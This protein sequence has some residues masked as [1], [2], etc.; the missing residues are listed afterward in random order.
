MEMDEIIKV[1][2]SK[3]EYIAQE[4]IT[5]Y[6][7]DFPEVKLTD[8]IKEAA[9][10]R[11]TSQLT[12]Q[13]SKFRFNTDGDLEEQFN[14]W[15]QETEE[16]DL[17]KSCRHSLEEEVKKMREANAGNL[18]SLDAYLKKHLGDVHQID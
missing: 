2:E 11:S 5:K 16:E 4:E 8:E 3:A 12:L 17:R 18:S 15:F 7:K 1:V 9:K 13:L 14:S 10:V 6:S